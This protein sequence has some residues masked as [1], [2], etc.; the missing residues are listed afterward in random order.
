MKILAEN[1]DSKVDGLK[2]LELEL[3]VMHQRRYDTRHE[4]LT[5]R[6]FFCHQANTKNALLIFPPWLCT[7]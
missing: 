7:I 2:S 4:I 1:T 5:K 3:A 6:T